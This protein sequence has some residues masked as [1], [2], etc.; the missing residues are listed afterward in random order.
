MPE[1]RGRLR[2]LVDEVL[3]AKAPPALEHTDSPARGCQTAGRD[4]ASEARADD[5]CVVATF[6]IR[7]GR[8]RHPTNL[9]FAIP[10]RLLNGLSNTPLALSLACTS[11][12]ESNC[13]Y[14]DAT[15]P[16]LPVSV[17]T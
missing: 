7:P 3:A 12:H 4:A 15:R 5:H 8:L 10:T 9:D 2:G 11:S 16:S 1:Q 13:W 17:F 14:I 6:A